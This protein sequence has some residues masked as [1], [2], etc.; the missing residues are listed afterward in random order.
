M[1]VADYCAN[2]NHHRRFHGDR[3]VGG[4]CSHGMGGGPTRLAWI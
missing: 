4:T 1:T 2:C 3:A